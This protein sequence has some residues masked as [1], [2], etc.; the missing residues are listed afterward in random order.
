MS[1]LTSRY[2]GIG[3]E[4]GLWHTLG[5][6]VSGRRTPHLKWIDCMVE[7]GESEF[8]PPDNT[9]LMDFIKR[10]KRQK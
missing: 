9:E 3:L 10:E 4:T 1:L 6:E 5:S 2:C 8:C 7:A